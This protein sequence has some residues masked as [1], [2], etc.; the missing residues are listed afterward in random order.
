MRL[1]FFGKGARGRSCLVALHEGGHSIARVVV[2]P[3]EK[4][5]AP[6]SVADLSEDLGLGVSAPEDPNSAEF[7]ASLRALAPEVLVLAGYGKILKRNVIEVPERL[8][9]N[10]HGG[11]VPEYR[12]S[13]PMNW[14]LIN[15]EKSFGLSV[16]EVTAG[17][18][19]GAVLLERSFE[20]A[21]G[22]TIHDLHARANEHFPQMLAEVL[23][24]LQGGTLGRREQDESKAGY[25]P[26]RFPEDGFVLFDQL[27]ADQ[28]HCRIRALTRPYPCAFTFYRGRRVDLLAS[29]LVRPPFYGEPGRIYRKTHGGLLVC[30]SD[31]CLRIT[32]AVFHDSGEPLSARAARYDSLA[33]LRGA[34]LAEMLGSDQ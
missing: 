20:I 26:L 22:D 2:H 21:P 32:E 33:T 6:G 14:A 17:V 8:C 15:G 11:R 29:E 23:E 5:G 1:V 25:Y 10:L 28:I 16:L 19:S 3:E 30:A 34:L 24:R 12:G 18:D 31:R 13:S 9:L 27:T 4:R 7:E